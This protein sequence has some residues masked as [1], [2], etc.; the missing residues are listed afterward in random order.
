[1]SDHFSRDFIWVVITSIASLGSIPYQ[2]LR[3]LGITGIYLW[4][5][6]N[7]ATPQKR[8]EVV[9]AGFKCGLGYPADTRFQLG[10]DVAR[11]ASA[12]LTAFIGTAGDGGQTPVLLDFEPSQGSAQFWLDFIWGSAARATKG[13]RGINGISSTGAP[14]YY[15]VTDFTPEPFKGTALPCS[16]LVA[17]RFDARV[18]YYFGGM[19]LVDGGEAR[20]DLQTGLNGVGFPREAI[21]GF[22]DGGRHNWPPIFYNGQRVRSLQGGTCIWNANLCREAGLI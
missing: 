10:D 3:D 22:V 18:Q 7:L 12:R 8:L 15:R 2:A 17:A 1:M 20:D 6:D 11:L 21:R 9:G 4:A 19:E 14:R 16:D 13:W 5:P